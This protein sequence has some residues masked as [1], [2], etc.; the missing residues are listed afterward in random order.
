MHYLISS[1]N[2]SCQKERGQK[3][4]RDILF[5]IEERRGEFLVWVIEIMK[6]Y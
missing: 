6:Q 3:A 5:G 2:E 1:L 4:S